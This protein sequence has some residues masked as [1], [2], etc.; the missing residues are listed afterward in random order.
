MLKLKTQIFKE[1]QLPVIFEAV[2]DTT[3][4]KIFKLI[5]RSRDL[6]V[7]DIADKLKLSMPTT[8]YHLK[9]LEL[10]G[11]V[12]PKRHGQMVCYELINKHPAVKMIVG[13]IKRKE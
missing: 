6:C 10:S 1:D 3:R 13:L 12:S 8:S 2:S 4:F 5:C 7:S 9:I 11:I